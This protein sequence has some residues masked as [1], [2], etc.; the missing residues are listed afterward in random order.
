MGGQG[1]ERFGEVEV[2]GELHADFFLAFPHPRDETAP[3][4]H[5]FPQFTDEVGVFGEPFHQ[6]GAGA[7]QCG[8]RVRDPLVRINVG[9]GLVVRVAG[10]VVEQRV[11]QGLQSGFA[12]DL[13]LGAALRLV[14][15]VDVFQACLGVGGHDRGFEFGREFALRLDR[16]QDDGAA[17]LQFPQVAQPLFDRPQL[18]VVEH[19][20]DFFAVAG[21]E[22]HGCA[23]VKQ[24]DCG[25][26]LPFAYP[27]LLG[28][29]L[30]NGRR[31]N[32]IRFLPEGGTGALCRLSMPAAAG[33]V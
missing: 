26:Y 19:L 4:P 6:D 12:R 15:E 30:V 33:V 25:P 31:H 32:L 22:R 24:F 21:D 8:S 1:G 18:G 9:G 29:P 5:A 3:L 17:F 23:V 13:R 11:R 7:F 28:D 20:R 27:E 14:G 2:V 10:G 16:L